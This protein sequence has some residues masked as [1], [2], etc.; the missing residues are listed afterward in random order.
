MEIHIGDRIAD[1]TLVGKEGNKVH[2]SFTASR[3]STSGYRINPNLQFDFAI[4]TEG[5][6]E[7]IFVFS[8]GKPLLGNIEST[9]H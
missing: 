9:N 8:T 2:L 6:W 1:I 5:H 4:Y 3:L 7:I